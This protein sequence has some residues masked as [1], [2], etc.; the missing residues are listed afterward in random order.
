M[1]SNTAIRFGVAAALLFLTA[2]V[3]P[4]PAH[5]QQVMASITGKVIGPVGRGGSGGESHGDRYRTWLGVE[6]DH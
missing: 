6:H 1:K 2:L 3:T 4:P 5:G